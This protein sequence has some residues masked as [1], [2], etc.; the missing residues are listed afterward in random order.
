M[1]KAASDDDKLTS[2]K[3]GQES[4]ARRYGPARAR[5]G[6]T[7][8]QVWQGVPTRQTQSERGNGHH[9]FVITVDEDRRSLRTKGRRPP[10]DVLIQRAKINKGMRASPNAPSKV[11]R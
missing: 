3:Q 8:W 6:S 5:T 9:G 4:P 10:P 1:A 11:G 2:E 7:A